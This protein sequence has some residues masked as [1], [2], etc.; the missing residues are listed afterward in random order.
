MEEI[1]GHNL[2]VSK[3]KQIVNSGSISHAY[4][5][6]GPRGIGKFLV[7]KMFAKM[8][9]CDSSVLRNGL[10]RVRVLFNFW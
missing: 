10:R 8:I 4:I 1:I 9:M 7:A 2:V 6:E 5:F 3:L